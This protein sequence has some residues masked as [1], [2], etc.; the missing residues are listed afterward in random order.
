MLHSFSV[1]TCYRRTDT[2]PTGVYWVVLSLE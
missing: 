1:G 2:Y